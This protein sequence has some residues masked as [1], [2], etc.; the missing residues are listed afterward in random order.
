MALAHYTN[1]VLQKSVSSFSFL[2]AIVDKGHKFSGIAADRHLWISTNCSICPWLITMKQDLWQQITCHNIKTYRFMDPH[3]NMMRLGCC[4]QSLLNFWLQLQQLLSVLQ[5]ELLR[6]F[7]IG[8]DFLDLLFCAI[9]RMYQH[10]HL[11]ELL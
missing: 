10:I 5:W 7:W 3:R 6:V 11:Q 1:K 9:V 2:I 8:C 4:Q